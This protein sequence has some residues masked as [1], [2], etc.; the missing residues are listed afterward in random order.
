MGVRAE[1]PLHPEPRVQSMRAH[2]APAAGESDA[3][4]L[5]DRPAHRGGAACRGSVRSTGRTRFQRAGH[6][7]QDIP[8][9][10]D[11]LD[12]DPPAGQAVE[13]PVLG[14]RLDPPDASFTELGHPCRS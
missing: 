4:H 5:G 8:V 6:L 10:R 2:A 14:L 12:V 13:P 11:P 3:A 1:D 9:P 7:W